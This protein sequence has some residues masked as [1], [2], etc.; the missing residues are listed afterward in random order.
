M[1]VFVTSEW[2]ESHLGAPEILL[3]DPRRPTHYLQGH[4]KTA[5]NLPLAKAF[6]QDG[7][8]RSVEYLAGWIGDAGLDEKRRPVIYDAY[9][10]QR[11]SMLAWLLEYLGRPD[12]HVMNVFLEGWVGEGRELYYRPVQ[13]EPRA[14]R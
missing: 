8:L 1:A 11:A 12:V 10:G 9:D 14:F 13:P 6:D 3:L 2:V 5:V 7:R 4:I